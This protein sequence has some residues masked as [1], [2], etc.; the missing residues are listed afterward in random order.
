MN[1]NSSPVTPLTGQPMTP[2]STPG[3]DRGTA[4]SKTRT[5]PLVAWAAL[6]TSCLILPAATELVVSAVN[7]STIFG[8]KSNFIE[9]YICLIGCFDIFIVVLFFSKLSDSL[10][11]AQT[12][13]GSLAAAPNSPV[14]PTPQLGLFRHVDEL[15]GLAAS[16]ERAQQRRWVQ[17]SDNL[18]IPATARSILDAVPT[19]IYVKDL[20]RRYV[21][22]NSAALSEL[23]RSERDILG[24]TDE[25]VFGIVPSQAIL[26]AERRVLESGLA[27]T[28]FE[29][30]GIAPGTRLLSITKAP[31]RD[32][33]GR[34]VGIIAVHVDVT[35]QQAAQ[36]KL[37]Q[38]EAKIM[39]SARL[40]AA[41]T[42]TAGWG[43]E[44]SQPL[45]AIANYLAA[46]RQQLKGNPNN[47]QAFQYLDTALEQTRR[48]GDIVKRLRDFIGKGD[49]ELERCR[50]KDLIEEA[51]R[52][53][54]VAGTS[55]ARAAPV[56]IGGADV[57]LLVDRVA[58]L[59]VFENI[60]RNAAEATAN[61]AEPRIDVSISTRPPTLVDIEIADN[62]PGI[63]PG[64]AEWIF[65][66]FH[67]TKSGGIGVGLALCRTI[68]DAH[69]GSIRA[70]N[71]AN[72]GGSFTITL[73]RV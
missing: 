43:H 67:S 70:S 40:H 30:R 8:I 6:V 28:L 53:V 38:L 2:I 34:I 29:E 10:L 51:A 22:A 18:A 33:A 26:D 46:A 48:A 7:A 59:Q 36:R 19:P 65:E 12:T 47:E 63:P 39:Q 17:I 71:A 62:G 5:L 56:T 44:L 69:G 16:V 68:V 42:M 11:W 55:G 20:E 64:D 73:T 35:C 54:L 50:L 66:P 31:W 9:I 4:P 57:A 25:V 23:R 15:Q 27:Q 72:S 61:T 3:S 37:H 45:A 32:S 49:R 52:S 24:K 14:S 1:P 58:M 13:I 21:S 41:A 60:L